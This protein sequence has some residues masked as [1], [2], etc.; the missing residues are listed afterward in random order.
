M[1]FSLFKKSINTEKINLTLIPFLERH[2]A[3]QQPKNMHAKLKH[4][5]EVT[6]LQLS[7][8]SNFLYLRRNFLKINEQKTSILHVAYISEINLHLI[9]LF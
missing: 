6:I 9:I 7:F 3:N 5:K 1:V 8:F 2:I 4:F